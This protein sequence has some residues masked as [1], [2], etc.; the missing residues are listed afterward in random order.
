M[1]SGFPQGSDLENTRKTKN[2]RGLDQYTFLQ[3]LIISIHKTSAML[4]FRKG[5]LHGHWISIS[6]VLPVDIIP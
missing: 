1:S 2:L 3:F 4:V 6:L 5:G